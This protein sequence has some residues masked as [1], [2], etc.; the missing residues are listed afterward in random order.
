MKSLNKNYIKINQLFSHSRK[1]LLIFPVVILFS[2]ETDNSP[3]MEGLNLLTEIIEENDVKEPIAESFVGHFDPINVSLD[4]NCVS[5]NSANLSVIQIMKNWEVKTDSASGFTIPSLKSDI[6]EF[7]FGEQL[8]YGFS[9]NVYEQKFIGLANTV[10]I[11]KDS[12]FVT[13]TPISSKNKSNE[14]ISHEY[15]T[16]D[17]KET[18]EFEKGTVNIDF[19]G[20]GCMDS[21]INS[22]TLKNEQGV[23]ALKDLANIQVFEFDLDDNGKKEVYLVSYTICIGHMEIYKIE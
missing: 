18:L 1:I 2:C 11:S 7:T 19:K 15:T 4:T 22:F 8:R 13:S 16:L 21:G 17:Q 5:E 14:L 6:P 20:L 3:G 23:L 9:I 10:F 12:V